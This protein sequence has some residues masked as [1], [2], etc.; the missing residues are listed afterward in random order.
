MAMYHGSEIP[1]QKEADDDNPAAFQ[2][3]VCIFQWISLDISAQC[4]IREHTRIGNAKEEEPFFN[5][6]A[7]NFRA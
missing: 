7:K 1:H 2:G 5:W 3:G 4:E 6:E